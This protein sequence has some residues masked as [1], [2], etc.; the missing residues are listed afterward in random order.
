ME[1]RSLIIASKS[2]RPILRRQFKDLTSFLTRMIAL[3]AAAGKIYPMTISFDSSP[4]PML[5]LTVN[6]ITIQ[7]TAEAPHI[8]IDKILEFALRHGIKPI[9]QTWPM[10]RDGVEEAMEALRAGKTRYRG[11]LVAQQ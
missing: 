4:V 8:Q 3:T 5:P 10:T 9:I 2:E 6:G 11:V 1:A 7:G